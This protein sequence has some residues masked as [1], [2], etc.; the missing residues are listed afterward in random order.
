MRLRLPHDRLG[1][2]A[3]VVRDQRR[4]AVV[5]RRLKAQNYGQITL[6]SCRGPL[7][8]AAAMH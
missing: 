7:P 4:R 3:P 6:I 5:A 1:K 8:E 2:N